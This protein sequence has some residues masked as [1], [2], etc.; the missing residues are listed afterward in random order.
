MSADQ[1]GSIAF[2]LGLN[3][4]QSGTPQNDQSETQPNP[5]YALLADLNSVPANDG[6]D[7]AMTTF[8]NQLS[9][10]T[11]ASFSFDGPMG[12][13]LLAEDEKEGKP[14]PSDEEKREEEERNRQRAA[15]SAHSN[16][17][18]EKLLAVDREPRSVPDGFDIASS[19]QLPPLPSHSAPQP[20]APWIG[21]PGPS[22][23]P[24]PAPAAPE[25]T[26]ASAR[27]GEAG[28]WDLTSTLALQYLLNKNPSV[29]ANLWQEQSTVGA[30]GVAPGAAPAGSSSAPWMPTNMP[31]PPPPPA[32]PAS[33]QRSPSATLVP[34]ASLQR[35]RSSS[36]VEAPPS[37][38]EESVSP[39]ATS[40]AGASG[41][42]VRSAGSSLSERVKLVDTGNPEADAE[43]NRLAIEED[44]RRRNTAASAR[45]RIK[46]KQREAALE[47]SARELESQ[48]NE[49]K[50]ENERLR[51]ENEWLRR[52]ITVRPEGLSAVMGAPAGQTS[53]PG[54]MPH[55]GDAAQ[56]P[57]GPRPDTHG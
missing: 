34:P 50:Q 37:A 41:T 22:P 45:F 52:L 31:P 49:L 38:P 54:L 51:T 4:F 35:K 53:Y 3:E 44:K 28:N 5:A 12:H 8:A 15:S 9:L 39:D 11:N 23:A 42:R 2:L 46:K 19:M 47:M 43:A 16:A 48:V 56:P 32:A 55:L 33:S 57:V 10:W 40:Q 6:S 13:A 29:V 20:Q 26:H 7:D 18:R 27:G 24:A 21:A 36:S 30:P 1:S 14:T 25:T 17:A